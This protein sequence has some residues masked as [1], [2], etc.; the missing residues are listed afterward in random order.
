[1][2]SSESSET[3]GQQET[4]IE[5]VNTMCFASGSVAKF[6]IAV[7][8]NDAFKGDTYDREIVTVRELVKLCQ[9]FC[10]RF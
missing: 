6:V 10:H 5:L 2:A 9:C 4:G 3:T 1:M 7:E 8:V